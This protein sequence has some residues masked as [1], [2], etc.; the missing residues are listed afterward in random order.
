MPPLDLLTSWPVDHGAGALIDRAGEWHFVGDPDHVFALASVTK[1]VTAAAV[2]VAHDEGTVDLALPIEHVAGA[3][4]ADLLAHCSGL[5]PDSR[6]PVTAPGRRR[7]YSNTGYE[8]LAERVALGAGFSFAEYVDE[9]VLQPL[10]LTRTTVAGSPAAG[11]SSS[12]RDLTRFVSAITT[13]RLLSDDAI[14]RFTTAHRPDLSGVLPGYGRQTPNP[15]GQGPEIRGH[16]APHWTGAGNHPTTWG[17]FGQ[18]GTFVWHDPSRSVSLIALTDR[19]FGPWA[20]E[21]W[22]VLSDAV[23]GHL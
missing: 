21:H 18:T 7:I 9:A 5:G 4:G 13:G 19:P 6:H 14:A 16:K 12:V 23:L 8:V 3:T 10:E 17:H 2:Q 11:A 22:P 1:L 15:W 20:I